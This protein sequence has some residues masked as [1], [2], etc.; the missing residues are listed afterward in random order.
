MAE[1]E[2]Y[3]FHKPTGLRPVSR[4]VKF[5]TVPEFLADE[6]AC[7]TLWDLV[8][9]QFNT[10]GKFLAIWSGV[11][12]VALSRDEAG[13]ADGFLLVNAPVNW[14]IDYVVVRPDRRGHGLAAALVS[15]TLNQAHLRGAPYVMLTSKAS[16]RPLH[17]LF[18]FS[19]GRRSGSLCLSKHKASETQDR[20]HDDSHA[21]LRRA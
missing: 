18:G 4:P 13:N 17:E 20:S 9:T 3:Y 14:Q 6:P 8:S 7:R 15:E 1:P 16:L 19:N 2:L 12:F 11:R 5:L 10:R 21:R